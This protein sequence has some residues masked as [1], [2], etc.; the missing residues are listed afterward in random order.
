MLI[1]N[2]KAEIHNAASTV[3]GTSEQDGCHMEIRELSPE[4]HSYA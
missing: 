4:K 2:Y 1:V 3:K